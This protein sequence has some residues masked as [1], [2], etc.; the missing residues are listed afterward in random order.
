MANL[1]V[2]EY[3]DLTVETH[4]GDTNMVDVPSA[5]L[6]KEN[7]EADTTYLIIATAI[8]SVDDTSRDIEMQVVHGNIADAGTVLPGSFQDIEH[9]RALQGVPYSYM[10]EF[11]QPSTT[12]DIKLQFRT[13]ISSETVQADSIH[14]LAIKVSDLNSANYKYAEDDDS[15]APVGIDA[16]GSDFAAIT[17][18]PDN[19]NDDWFVLTC[20]A[21]TPAVNTV[22][23]T[24][25]IDHGADSAPTAIEETES[26][27]ANIVH[28]MSRTYTLADSS[29]TFTLHQSAPTDTDYDHVFSTIIALNIK[30]GVEFEDGAFDWDETAFTFT[31]A[32]VDETIGQSPITPTTTGN[33][34]TFYSAIIDGSASDRQGTARVDM[35]G[36]DETGRCESEV[37]DAR[38]E[39]AIGGTGLANL[40]SGASRAIDMIAQ[41]NNTTALIEDRHVCVFSIKLAAVA[42]VDKVPTNR[43]NPRLDHYSQRGSFGKEKERPSV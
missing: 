20:F 30:S 40:T 7:F 22:S 16:A 26:S 11:T 29:Q 32:D 19:N 35:A 4:T 25:Q 10:I 42:A 6:P 2:I 5:E 33:F 9:H 1:T 41:V 15:G 14:L 37:Y 31:T 34:I 17:F 13:D 28:T 8:M 12:E 27:I 23:V 43:Y 38:D 36:T 24:T 18:T 21:Y 39:S 3:T